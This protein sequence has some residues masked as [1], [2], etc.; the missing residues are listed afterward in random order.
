MLKRNTIYGLMLLCSLCA[1]QLAHAANCTLTALPSIQ[2]TAGATITSLYAA[3]DIRNPARPKA[4]TASVITPPSSGAVT[5]LSKTQYN[6]AAPLAPAVPSLTFVLGVTC[7]DGTRLTQTVTVNFPITTVPVTPTIPGLPVPLPS[8]SALPPTVAGI[9]GNAGTVSGNGSIIVDNTPNPGTVGISAN[10]SIFNG[11]GFLGSTSCTGTQLYGVCNSFSQG[12]IQIMQR[13]AFSPTLIDEVGLTQNTCTGACNANNMCTGNALDPVTGKSVIDPAT[14]KA[15]PASGACT[16]VSAGNFSNTTRRTTYFANGQHLFDLDR[17]RAAADYLYDYR[18]GILNGTTL[19]T[20]G[21]LSR[22]GITP[23]ASHPEGTYGTISWRQFLTNIKNSQPMYGIVRVLIPLQMGTASGDPCPTGAGIK[24]AMYNTVFKDATGATITYTS[25]AAANQV[26]GFCQTA[27]GM[28]GTT[29][30]SANTGGPGI[31]GTNIGAGSMMSGVTFPGDASLRVYG[32]LLFDYVSDNNYLV[33]PLAGSPN[34]RTAYRMGEAIDLDNLHFDAKAW[35]YIKVQ[36][37]II[38]NPANDRC[39]NN[40]AVMTNYATC[41]LALNAAGQVSGDG[42]MDNLEYIDSLTTQTGNANGT[43]SFI[44]P[45]DYAQVPQEAK[46]AYLFHSGKTLDSIEFAKLNLANQYHTLMPSG[47]PGGW[48]KAF[49]ELNIS[50][51][52]W[53]GMPLG[54]DPVTNQARPPFGVPMTPTPNSPLSIDDIRGNGFEDIPVYLYSGGLV[55]MHYHVN[56]SGLV[57]VPQSL[58]LEARNEN[59]NYVSP[60]PGAGW[61]S[62]QY[63]GKTTTGYATGTGELCVMGRQYVMGAVIMR[64]GFYIESS[65]NGVPTGA[66]ASGALGITGSGTITLFSSDPNSF[67]NIRVLANASTLNSFYAAT[68]SSSGAGKLN[69]GSAGGGTPPAATGAGFGTIVG[70]AGGTAAGNGI[71]PGGNQ[72]IQVRPQR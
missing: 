55:D 67:S 12:A 37:P 6:Y 5:I 3:V 17:L 70:G 71:T 33:T 43:Y 51:S 66:L 24:N 54:T 59:C 19:L 57:Y 44:A 38:V 29:G 42:A 28:C 27:T 47:Y 34:K 16:S 62:A 53:G 72:W 52:K 36:V 32:S 26:F 49:Q 9:N 8:V 39:V 48:A 7:P 41:D 31:G 1:T 68:P 22:M 30:G 11:A 18:T 15:V 25:C 65:P 46:D 60:T 50:A 23:S 64:D 45:I 40:G 35:T 69:N 61:N 13:V 63:W 14:G 56:V 10:M 2:A 20:S 58:E 4:L 21:G